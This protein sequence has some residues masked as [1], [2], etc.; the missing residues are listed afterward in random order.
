[1]QGMNFIVP[2]TIVD[3]Y[4]RKAKIRPQMSEVSLVYE[5][6][7]DLYD[8][9]RYIKALDKFDEVKRMNKTFPFIDKMI[10]DTER[11]I[12]RGLDKEPKDMTMYYYIGGGVI[13]LALIL[14]LV[15]RKRKKAI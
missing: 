1:V 8:N 2:S 14:F 15:F 4:I 11:K 7:L 9:E 10:A 12:D 5:E 6:G 13:L 3:E